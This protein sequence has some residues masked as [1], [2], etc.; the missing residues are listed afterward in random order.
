M[1]KCGVANLSV[2][3]AHSMK[4]DK[5]EHRQ[6]NVLSYFTSLFNPFGLH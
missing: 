6:Y 4:L 3:I 2:R 1:F 5:E